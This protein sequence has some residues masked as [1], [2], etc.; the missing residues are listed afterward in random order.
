M[1]A[2]EIAIVTVFMAA[3]L[4]AFVM[5]FAAP[6]EDC[7]ASSAMSVVSLFAPCLQREAMNDTADSRS[8]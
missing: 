1:R 6:A 3:A 2:H 8:R 7:A 5:R 4:T